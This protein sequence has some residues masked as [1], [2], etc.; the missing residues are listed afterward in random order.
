MS[1]EQANAAQ[2]RQLIPLDLR[3]I[4]RLIPDDIDD[5]GRQMLVQVAARGVA[6]TNSGNSQLAKLAADTFRTVFKD[7]GGDGTSKW[8]SCGDHCDSENNPATY[9]FC[10]WKCVLKGG[11]PKK[12]TQGAN[13]L[14]V[15]VLNS[16]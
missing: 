3:R 2:G 15:R 5:N 7:N 14:A 12:L 13:D 9:G 6:A 11:P 8:E 10:Y 4:E 16:P 1:G